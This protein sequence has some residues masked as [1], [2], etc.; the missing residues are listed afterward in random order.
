MKNSVELYNRLAANYDQHFAEPHRAAYD[1]LAWDEVLQHLPGEGATV[2]DAGCGIGRW[3][4]QLI[5]EGHYVIG[6]ER[7][8]AMISAARERL[9][10]SAFELR[11]GDMEQVSLPAS[12]ADAVLAMGALQYTQDPAA[13][14]TRF[15]QWLK[16]GGTLFLLYD[17]RLALV[18]E[19]L[20]AGRT[21]EAVQRAQTG[22]GYW[23]MQDVSADLHLFSYRDVETYCRLANL[24]DM[25]SMGLLVGASAYGVPRLREKLKKNFREQIELERAL[26]YVPELVA[27]GK[28]ILT[29]ARKPLTN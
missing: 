17:S 5:A 15:A 23:R 18:I 16:P 19:L 28:Q 24:V 27:A 2:V 6:I 3:A 20:R 9:P 10:S 11:E 12:C 13:T 8:P 29:R 14:I 22:R 25:S 26:M 7:A 4:E 1:R 21:E